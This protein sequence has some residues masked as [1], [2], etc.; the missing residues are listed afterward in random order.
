MRQSPIAKKFEM[1]KSRKA[2]VVRFRDFRGCLDAALVVAVGRSDCAHPPAPRRVENAMAV[3]RDPS[4]S[5]ELRGFWSSP[6]K[7]TTIFMCSC[8]E[9]TVLVCVYLICFYTPLNMYKCF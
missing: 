1:M 8:S 5:S 7:S 4:I 9:D 2:A 3:E 6:P